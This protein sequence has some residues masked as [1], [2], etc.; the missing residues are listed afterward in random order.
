MSFWGDTGIGAVAGGPFGAVTGAAIGGVGDSGGLGGIFGWNASQDMAE[1]QLQEAQAERQQT[2]GFAGATPQELSAHQAQLGLATQ[3]LQQAQDQMGQYALMQSQINPAFSSAFSQIQGLLQGQQ[4]GYTSPYFKQLDI[5]RQQNN[6]SLQNAMGSGYASSTAG[7]QAQALF[8]QQA[9]MGAMNVTQNALQS[10][11]GVGSGA[12][13]AISGLGQ[14]GMAGA[15][16]ASNINQQYSTM[17]GNVQNREI[18]ASLG[19]STTQYQGA[20]DVSAALQGQALSS[21]VNQQMGM[22]A[23]LLGGSSTNGSGGGAGL[24]MLMAA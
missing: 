17:L 23:Q 1:Q 4:V 24:G 22:G 8:A 3:T 7:A 9:G 15:G 16:N 21:L 19:S 14:A 13:S 2:L 12:A 18:G 5:Q 6:N 10:L 11:M 20:N